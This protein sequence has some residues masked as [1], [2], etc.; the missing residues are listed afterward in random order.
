MPATACDQIRLLLTVEISSI[1]L[2]PCNSWLLLLR[3][4]ALPRQFIPRPALFI[5]SFLW[6]TTFTSFFILLAFKV[7]STRYQDPVDLCILT[8]SYHP[9]ALSIPFISLVLFDTVAVYLTSMGLIAPI[10]AR[11]WNDRITRLV[12]PEYMGHISRIFLR[13]GQV[14]YGY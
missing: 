1:I 9:K 2:I 6:V 13:T 14:Y 4:K 5:C 12:R 11:T 10:P 7:S 3:I 8:V